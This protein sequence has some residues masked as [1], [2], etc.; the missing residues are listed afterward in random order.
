MD[1][2]KSYVPLFHFVGGLIVTSVALVAAAMAALKG[3]WSIDQWK[4]PLLSFLAWMAC[5]ILVATFVMAGLQWRRSHLAKTATSKVEP[6]L[7]EKLI[8]FVLPALP[9]ILA[10]WQLIRLAWVT[11]KAPIVW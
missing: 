10:A 11:V 2:T 1:E 8:A 9:G 4:L 3:A 7:G 5:T 6:S